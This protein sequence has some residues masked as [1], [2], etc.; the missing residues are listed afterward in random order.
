[1]YN[2]LIIYLDKHNIIFSGKFGFRANHSTAHALL[3]ITDQ[4]QRAIEGGIFLDLSQAFDTVDHNTLLA[5]LYSY[6]IRGIAYDCFLS[7]L[8]N[9]CPFVS[10]GNTSSTSNPFT[11][12]VPQGSVLGPLYIYIYIYIYMIS[13]TVLLYLIYTVSLTIQIYS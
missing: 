9:C 11:S 2:R 5:K 8:S 1:M 3:L 13:V 10:I 7:Y 4:I 6:G 12:G